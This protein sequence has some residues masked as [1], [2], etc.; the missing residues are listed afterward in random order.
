LAALEALGVTEYIQ[1]ARYADLDGFLR[2]LEPML[3]RL[4]AHRG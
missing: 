4:E 3:E 2:A 1:G